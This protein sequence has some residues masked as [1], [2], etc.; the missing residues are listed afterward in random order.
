M[1]AVSVCFHRLKYKLTKYKRQESEGKI[2]YWYFGTPR[3]SV[4]IQYRQNFYLEITAITPCLTNSNIAKKPTMTL[5]FYRCRFWKTHETH[6]QTSVH[7][8]A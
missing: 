7:P 8:L 2:I 1:M 5:I 3:F 6:F 4:S